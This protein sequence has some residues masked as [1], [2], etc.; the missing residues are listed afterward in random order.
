MRALTENECR[1]WCTARGV[2]LDAEGYPAR[3]GLGLT[4]IRARHPGVEQIAWFARLIETALQPRDRLLLWVTQ[5]GVWPTGENWHLYY[6]LRES[7]GDHR[8]LDEAPGHLFLN[9]ES[10]D[11]VSFVQLGLL[12]GWDMH[13][14]PSFGYGLVFASH[15]AWVDFALQ[16]A[17]AADL[18]STLEKAELVV[19][20]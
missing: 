7:Y 13:L 20:S 4:T 18:R 17:E 11:V 16:D 14:T 12:S 8:L 3:A 1:A 2:V 9:Y 15:D 6:R 10:A 5:C 19:E